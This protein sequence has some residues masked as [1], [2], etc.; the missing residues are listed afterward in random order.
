ML[1]G[2]TDSAT[3]GTQVGPCHL[4]LSDWIVTGRTSSADEVGACGTEN[5][6][7]GEGGERIAGRSAPKTA[8][9]TA[10]SPRERRALPS[11]N[12]C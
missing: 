7:A 10:G 12:A 4:W 9:A 11:D 3:P 2:R 8:K 6:A 1:V 5:A